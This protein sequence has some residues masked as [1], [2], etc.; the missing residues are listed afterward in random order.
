MVLY[1]KLIHTH[2]KSIWMTVSQRFPFVI[3]Y[4]CGVLYFLLDSNV[5]MTG[6]FERDLT[7]KLV[8]SVNNKL[9]LPMVII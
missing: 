1:C 4:L 9:H 7:C 2:N 3:V 8:C 5:Q 6:I